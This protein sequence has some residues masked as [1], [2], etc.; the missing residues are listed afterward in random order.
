MSSFTID[1]VTGIIRFTL[2]DNLN[3]IMSG[4]D[5]PYTCY[6]MTGKKEDA[7]KFEFQ[8]HRNTS[9]NRDLEVMVS[10]HYYTRHGNTYI[11]K[12]SISCRDCIINNLV[13][14][15][16]SDLEILLIETLPNNHSDFL[17]IDDINEVEEQ[18]SLSICSDWH[19]RFNK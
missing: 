15:N 8:L 14:N 19:S 13:N 12:Y 17:S 9:T 5:Q 10:N 4:G 2:V 11:L 18:L 16:P 3:S 6:F 7:V 1:F